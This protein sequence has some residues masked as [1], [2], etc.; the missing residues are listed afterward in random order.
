MIGVDDNYIT[1]IHLGVILDLITYPVDSRGIICYT[2]GMSKHNKHLKA[3]RRTYEGLTWN[4]LYL[5]QMRL[6]AEYIEQEKDR[7]EVLDTLMEYDLGAREGSAR[8]KEEGSD[9]V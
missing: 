3:I 9:D 2:G 8:N 6:H 7:K 5:E 1:P 4:K